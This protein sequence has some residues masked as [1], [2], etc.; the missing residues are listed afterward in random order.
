M[1]AF[2]ATEE[3]IERW[4]AA[5]IPES[6][7]EIFEDCMLSVTVFNAMRTQWD[8]AGEAGVRTGLRYDRVPVFFRYLRVPV[9]E[10][11]RVFADLMVMEAETLS[12]D[13]EKGRA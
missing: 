1:R 4:K 10:R 3:D 9:A 8:R 12:V 7:L 2:G 6:D 13:A 5:Q 11:D